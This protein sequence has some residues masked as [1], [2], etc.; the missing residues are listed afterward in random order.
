LGRILVVDD[1]ETIRHLCCEIL[2]NAGYAA[3]ESADG[4]RALEM[5]EKA[6]Y[7]LVVSDIDMPVVN[8][9]ELFFNVLWRYPHLN[10]RF[11]FISGNPG[12]EDEI[13]ERMKV[14]R[15]IKPFTI[16]EFVDCVRSLL[17]NLPDNGW[18][19]GMHGR[20]CRDV[21]FAVT[22]RFRL[23]ADRDEER[24]LSVIVSDISRSG[25]R[26]LYQG[27]SLEPGSEVQL[28]GGINDF[29]LRT[30]AT[31]VWSSPSKSGF[32]ASGLCF[33]DLIS[34]RHI[35]EVS[36]MRLDNTRGCGR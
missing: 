33:E 8:G 25:A 20:V 14:R 16:A 35:M 22:A 34:P 24:M 11:L 6:K 9:V 29:D 19:G 32:S 26:V 4:A 30:A 7:D 18:P 3:D 17:T 13:V 1:D 36:G 15:L 28:R 12:I 2:D 27:A 10:E 5:L 31:V 21:R 23:A